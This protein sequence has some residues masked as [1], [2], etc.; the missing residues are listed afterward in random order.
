MI[1]NA[2]VFVLLVL[3]MAL[4]AVVS[5]GCADTNERALAI[6]RVGYIRADAQP[7]NNPCGA[8]NPSGGVAWDYGNR[9]L[10]VE[11]ERP[12]W[13]TK[14]V[15]VSDTESPN[16]PKLSAASVRV[17]HS[18]DNLTYELYDKPMKFALARS[19]E[20]G[21]VWR[22]ELS[23]LGFYT[24][25]IKLKQTYN[26]ADYGFGC[27]NIAECAQVFTDP[28]GPGGAVIEGFE[29]A[30]AQSVGK[31]L[32]HVLATVEVTEDVR[33]VVEAENTET[34]ETVRSEVAF[35]SGAWTPATLDSEALVPGG[36]WLTAELFYRDQL[37]SEAQTCARIHTSVAEDPG[38][39]PRALPAGGAV[40]LR[41]LPKRFSDGREFTYT[42]PYAPETDYRGVVL[43]KG[44]KQTLTAGLSG[45]AAVYV[46]AS[47]PW[48]KLQV[49]WGEYSATIPATQGDWQPRSGTQELFCGFG[50][51]AKGP[52]TIEAVGADCKVFHVRVVGLSGDEAALARYESDP[53]HNRRVIYNNDGFSEL[54]GVKDWDRARLLKLVERYQGTDTEIF[55]MAAWV[56]GAVSFPSKY[57]TF[58]KPDDPMLQLVQR[59]RELG[60]PV[61]GSL[62]MS[63]YYGIREHQTVQPFNGKLWHERPEMRQRTKSGTSATQMSYAWKE[64]QQERIGVLGE[65]AEM[66]CE[67]VMMDFCRYPYILGYDEPL[68]EGFK[69][70]YGVSPLDLPDDDERWISYRC[71]FMNDFFRAVRA[72][73]DE[74][75]QQQGRKIRISVRVPAS[76]YRSYGFDPETWAREKLMDIFIPHFPGLEKDFDVR[77]WVEMTKGTGILVY[78]G[79]TPTKTM[80]STTELTDAQVKAG[81]KPGRVTSMSKNDYRRK[82]WRR[83]R[84]G[85]DGVFLFNTWRIGNTRNLLGDKRALEQWS[86]FEDPMNLPRGSVAEQ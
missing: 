42:L 39:A 71:E 4:G 34:W 16:E 44:S 5:P 49:K 32:A 81:V 74:V 47:N 27:D 50:D 14:V 41:D 10:V 22:V 9:S 29:V 23:G 40:V 30:P 35:R 13:V 19:K 15:L 59:G 37:L 79:M 20:P 66:G 48:P 2:Q 18:R 82:A 21:K 72:R 57:A 11:L 86:R 63:A 43:E 24:R 38:E 1:R 77:P 53:E 84:K 36:Y 26:G 8:W 25:Y 75:A 6:N 28:A 52:L 3:L 60:I 65:M 56:S 45:F 70:K 7:A 83:Y 78:P 64:V 62:R 51:F 68:V 55:E 31:L 17:Y 58:W 80:T 54:W 33:L 76:G 46:A 69:A 67:G 73:I 85:A 12:Q 61:W